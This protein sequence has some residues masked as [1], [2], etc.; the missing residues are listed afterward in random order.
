[1]TSTFRIFALVGFTLLLAS[2]ATTKPEL[3]FQNSAVP[4]REF[5]AAWVATVANIDWPSK[6]GLSSHVQKEE[7]RM[8]LDRAVALHLNAIVL[9]I[10]PA[11]DALY[12]SQIEPWSEYLT[13][14]MGVPPTPYYDPLRFAVEEAHRRGLELHVWFNPFRALHPAGESAVSNNHI[15]ITRPDLV[16]QY[17]DY[18]WLDPGER[19]ARL[20]SLS[21]IRDVVERYDIDGVHM[22]D[23]FYPYD[24]K[25][26]DGNSVQ[27]PDTTSW[28]RAQEKGESRSRDDWRRH[29]INEFVRTMYDQIKS[30]KPWVKVGL[31]PFGIW[32]PGNPPQIE[33]YDAY[34]MLYADSRKWLNEGWIDYF[35][36]QLYWNIEKPEQSY[37]VLLEWWIGEN[38]RQRHIWPGNY[39]SRTFLE[40]RAHWGPE[41]IIDQI[42]VT[43]EFQDA[44]GN[45]HF[46]MK[47]LFDNGTG[48]ADMLSSGPYSSPALVPATPWLASGPAPLPPTL[49][50][51]K[52]GDKLLLKMSTGEN[53]PPWLWAIAIRYGNSWKHEVAPGWRTYLEIDEQIA[54]RSAESIE[55]RVVDR[56]GRTSSPQPIGV[57]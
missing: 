36:P 3:R 8:I 22:D 28:M 24:I 38:R 2:C 4:D 30:I 11:A 14:Q 26:D 51:E 18:L 55:V 57:R 20:L 56:L 21:V 25:D 54:G 47:A 49:Q 34:A 37:P 7:L 17:G 35:T 39:T 10:R 53:R 43:R 46:S 12:P 50:M 40:G 42:D 19:E 29:N 23:Y 52:L 33:G 1:M 13:G 48:M 15:S 9:Q 27:F 44:T 41:E 16:K 6:P 31:S 5:R 32:R 45:V